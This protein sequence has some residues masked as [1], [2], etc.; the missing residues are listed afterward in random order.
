MSQFTASSA[1]GRRGP[2]L[3]VEQTLVMILLGFR[4]D[5]A[6]LNLHFISAWILRRRHRVDISLFILVVV[7]P[8][9]VIA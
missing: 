3:R 7:F 5:G 6:E 1:T 8:D 4:V 2:A 9:I